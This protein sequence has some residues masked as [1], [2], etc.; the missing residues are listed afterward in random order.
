MLVFRKQ[1][2]LFVLPHHEAPVQ[3]HQPSHFLRVTRQPNGLDDPIASG[4]VDDLNTDRTGFV[5][6]LTDKHRPILYAGRPD[7][8]H[9]S[10]KIRTYDRLSIR[11]G[12]HG[13]TNPDL[14]RGRLLATLCEQIAVEADEASL[15]PEET[16]HRAERR[17]QADSFSLSV[18]TRVQ[19]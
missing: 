8:E 4:F 6:L 13:I 12:T 7:P 17:Q 5:G 16:L 2:I 9:V 19:P 15:P 10:C 18:A 11:R 3:F 1:R 14:L